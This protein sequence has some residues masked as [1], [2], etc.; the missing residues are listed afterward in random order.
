MVALAYAGVVLRR[1]LDKSH[2]SFLRALVWPRIAHLGKHGVSHHKNMIEPWLMSL[3][4]LIAVSALF[5]R[6][7]LA[8]V[9]KFLLRRICTHKAPSC[10]SA[11]CLYTD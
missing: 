7:N 4:V 8:L 11:I 6:Q 2:E 1:E 9:R 10:T 5:V 3:F